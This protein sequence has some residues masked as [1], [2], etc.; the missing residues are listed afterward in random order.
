MYNMCPRIHDIT[1]YI[2]YNRCLH[3]S[4]VANNVDIQ[5]A[6]LCLECDCV[7]T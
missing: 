5:C 7:E 3:A 1:Y 6:T 2:R 4:H